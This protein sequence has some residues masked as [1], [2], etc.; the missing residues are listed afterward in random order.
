MAKEAFYFTHDYGSRNDPKLQKVLMK[1]GHEGKSVYWDLVEMMY[2]EGGYLII[3]EC[4]NYAFALRTTCDRI[5]MLIK[6]FDLFKFNDVHFWSDSILRRLDKRDEKSKKASESAKLR[7]EKA[8]ALK[9]DANATNLDA[10]KEKK[11]KE[12]IINIPELPLPATSG[13][14]SNSTRVLKF[15]DKFNTIKESHVGIKGKFQA[16][17][18]VTASFQSR[19]RK[20]DAKDIVKAIEKAF[21]HKMHVEQNFEYLTPEYILREDILERYINMSE[22]QLQSKE[23]LNLFVPA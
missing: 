20:Y 12:N 18:K 5:Q 7:W 3:S 11:G 23:P 17:K 22:I 14:D 21:K 2:E 10:I 6:D 4:D 1:M 9:E 16:T 8:N 19:I 15:V 13:T